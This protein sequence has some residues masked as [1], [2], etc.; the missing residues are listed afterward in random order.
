MLSGR[1]AFHGTSPM[2]VVSSTLLA[3]PPATESNVLLDELIDSCLAKQPEARMQSSAACSF[4]LTRIANRNQRTLRDAGGVTRIAVV[5]VES[6]ST[7]EPRRSGAAV[8]KACA[9]QKW[10]FNATRQASPPRSV[11]RSRS[12]R[13]GVIRRPS[14]HS[15]RTRSRASLD[16]GAGPARLRVHLGRSTGAGRRAV[17]LRRD[18]RESRVDVGVGL[19]I[20]ARGSSRAGRRGLDILRRKRERNA[21]PAIALAWCCANLGRADEAVRWLDHAIRERCFELV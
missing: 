9:T 4:V 2:D 15:R 11:L 3:N 12:T 21:L 17:D 20:L 5:P 14:A 16:H 1:R 10:P 6:V 13:R 18:G 8:R 7:R 19:G